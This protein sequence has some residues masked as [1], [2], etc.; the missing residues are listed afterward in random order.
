M[1]CLHVS[2]MC[3]AM[4]VWVFQNL[5]LKEGSAKRQRDQTDG[6]ALL[7]KG[8]PGHSGWFKIGRGAGVQKRTLRPKPF[9][10]NHEITLRPPCSTTSGTLPRHSSFTC[11]KSVAFRSPV[12]TMPPRQ[13]RIRISLDP[14]R[15]PRAKGRRRHHPPSRSIQVAGESHLIQF[16]MDRC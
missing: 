15:R 10:T 8:M 12:S 6:G 9:S 1:R 13:I 3:V 2:V 11:A 16:T 14:G 5:R 4:L 7:G